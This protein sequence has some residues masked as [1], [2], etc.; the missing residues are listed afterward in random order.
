MLSPFALVLIVDSQRI[1]LY[2]HILL[3]V[4]QTTPPSSIIDP[5]HNL[6]DPTTSH[7]G[8]HSLKFSRTR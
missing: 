8:Q 7:H 5:Y 1:L 4:T 6:N 2:I 3:F